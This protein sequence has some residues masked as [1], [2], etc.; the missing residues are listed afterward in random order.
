MNVFHLVAA[1]G[2]LGLFGGMLLV[3]LVLSPR[4]AQIG[5]IAAAF[6]VVLL[7]LL[8]VRQLLS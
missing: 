8:A 6:G 2:L 1:A 5:T 4:A 7:A 3:N